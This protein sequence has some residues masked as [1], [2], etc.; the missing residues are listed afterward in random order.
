MR[1][2]QNAVTHLLPEVVKADIQ[3]E[4]CPDWL[5]RPGRAECADRWETVSAL[6]H[7]LTGLVLPEQAPPRER[8]SLDVLLTY[9]DG[10]RQIL[11][12]DEKQHFTAARALTL[13]HYPADVQLGFDAS[14]WLARSRDLTGREPGG[15]FAKPRPPL[16]PGEGGRHRQRAFR[17]ALADLLPPVYGWLPTLRLSDTEVKTVTAAPDPAASLR[18]L[19]GAC[20]VPASR[21]T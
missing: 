18:A 1:D 3:P 16:F 12:V 2:L 21:F 13:E 14:R 11:E 6:Y 10:Q 15:G 19:L 9:E 17:D 5:R 8:R 7:A 4:S 20:G